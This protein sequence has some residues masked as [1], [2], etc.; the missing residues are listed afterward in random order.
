MLVRQIALPAYNIQTAVYAEHAIIVTH[1]VTLDAS[2]I[3]C[4]KPILMCL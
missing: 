3:R 4:L 2:D 1:D